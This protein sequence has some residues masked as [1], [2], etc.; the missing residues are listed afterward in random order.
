MHLSFK[1]MTNWE[2]K[3]NGKS[4]KVKTLKKA[5]LVGKKV[6][7]DESEKANENEKHV[8]NQKNGFQEYSIQENNNL[9]LFRRNMN[10]ILKWWRNGV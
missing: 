5:L 8:L 4:K 9:S 6:M 7:N 1:E 10:I 3:Q 2:W